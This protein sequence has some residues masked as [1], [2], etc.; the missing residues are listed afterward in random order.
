MKV[1]RGGWLLLVG[2]VC[3]GA[4]GVTAQTPPLPPLVLRIP[5]SVRYAGLN[6]A[7]SALVGDAGAVFGNPAGLATIAHIAVEGA[8]RREPFRGYV[9]TAAAAWRLRQF[10]VGGGV[11]YHAVGTDSGVAGPPVP[12]R[13]YELLAVGSL[14]YRYGL[15]AL[16]VS[17]K[18]LRTSALGV[19][20]RGWGGDLGLAIAVFDI[21][22]IGF[23]V[24]NVG[25]N[26][27]RASALV[28]PRL[29][30]LGFTL[31][32]VDPLE[33][34]RLRSILEV[35]WPSGRGARL[36]VGGEAGTVIK[37]VGVVGRLAYGSRWQD[38][39]PSSVTYGASFVLTRFV[40]A[41][42]SYEPAVPFADSRHRL[43][44]RLTL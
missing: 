29:T 23:S 38:Y 31:N 2:A 40:T 21:M 28:W 34:F 39:Q 25:G 18:W 8:Y 42:Y 26:L 15:I 16:G 27:D 11:H 32:Y 44:I 24:Q 14:V 35:Q 7:G 1:P 13:P 12:G 10:D 19:E 5:G 3:A 43:G 6:G 4:R 36:I 17:G 37:G 20:E 9:G 30:R 33:S 22:A 41:D